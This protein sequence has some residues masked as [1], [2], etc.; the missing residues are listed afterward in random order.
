MAETAAAVHGVAGLEP[1][2]GRLAVVVG[3]FD[4]LHRGHRHL[5]RRLVRQARAWRARP[6]VITFD[7][8]P[9]A[10]LR[11]HAPPLLLDPEE[12]GA[13]LAAA[14]VEVVVVEHFDDRLRTTPFETFVASIAE[15]VDVA[16]FVMTPESAFGHERRGTPAA[17]AALGAAADRPF[18]VAVVPALIVDGRPVSS[19]AIRTAIGDGDLDLARRL[20]GR[21][22]AVVGH[23]REAGDGRLV[24][25]GMPV[26]LPPMG[27]YEVGVTGRWQPGSRARPGPPATVVDGSSV[28]LD[29]GLAGPVRIAFRRRLPG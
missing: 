19:S 20:L 24:T 23:A 5:L 22:H 15:R 26:A 17:L 11:G 12:R 29:R 18:D 3:V 25:F 6:A 7:A 28:A 27:R 10:V 4:G 2:H 9:D 21:V 1:G 13:R 8:H 16:G 14:G